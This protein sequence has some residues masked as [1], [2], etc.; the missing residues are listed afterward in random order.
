MNPKTRFLIVLAVLLVVVL[1]CNMPI[2]LKTPVPGTP[3]S[4]AVQEASATAPPTLAPA[5][6]TPVEP[7]PTAAQPPADT[8]VPP[9]AAPS[10]TGTGIPPTAS[11]TETATNT[12]TP[13]RTATRTTSPYTSTPPPTLTPEPKPTRTRTAKPAVSARTVFT[14]VYFS[15]PPVLDG[16]WDEWKDSTGENP[17]RNVV[18]GSAN[19]TGADDLDASFRVAWDE[20][21]LYLAVKVRDDVYVQ[22]ASGANL[23]E[24]DSLEVLLDNDLLG[25]LYTRS[26]SGDDYQLGISPGNPEAGT[27]PEAFLWFPGG[28]AG[29]RA[30]VKIAAVRQ[31]GVT[32]IE[33]AVP[34]NV[35]GIV[36]QAGDRYGFALSVSDNDNP[37]ANVQESMVSSAARRVLVDPTTWNELRLK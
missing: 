14:A 7:V 3:A 12:N 17:A 24:G 35:F 22:N 25:D 8:P 36:P 34:W 4:T 19:W 30:K 2:Q 32:R 15:A 6:S 28:A 16:I 11:F 5:A 13:T 20:V 9:A 29:A 1:A 33:A 23:Y 31:D 18:Y 10:A 27:D 26:L 37:A 21:Y